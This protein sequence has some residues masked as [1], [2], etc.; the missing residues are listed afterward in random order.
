VIELRSAWAESKAHF[1]VSGEDAVLLDDSGGYSGRK[2]VP[3]GASARWILR[4]GEW[5]LSEVRV[6]GDVLRADNTVGKNSAVRAAYRVPYNR[7]TGSWT[8][9]APQWLKDA[10]AANDPSVG[11]AD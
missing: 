11:V 9:D 8:E 6:T 7:K 2:I 5:V 3:V 10:V 1:T 4:R